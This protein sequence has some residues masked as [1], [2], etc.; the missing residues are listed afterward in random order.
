MSLLIYAEEYNGQNFLS[1]NV[2]DWVDTAFEFLHRVD[3]SAAESSNKCVFNSVGGV[4]WWELTDGSEWNDHGFVGGKTIDL[5]TTIVGVGS[6]IFPATI[7]YIDG[8]KMYFTSD[9][10]AGTVPDQTPSPQFDDATGQLLASVE[11]IQTSAPES[12]EYDFNLANVDNPSLNSLI[13]G[14]INRFKYVDLDL[15][16]ILGTPQIMSPV[17][18]RSGGYFSQPRIQYV[19]NIDGYRKY[20]IVYFFFVWPLIQDGQT[21]PQWF[22]GVD[23][24]GANHRVRVFSQLNN[25]NSILQDKSTNTDGNV[26]GFDENFNTST[27][28]FTITNAI[29]KDTTGNVIEGID[30]CDTT[31][32]EIQIQ[33]SNSRLNTTYSR[34]NIGLLWRPND[35]DEYSNNLNNF[36]K[37]TITN[38]PM[39]DFVHTLTPDP[40]T[41]NGNTKNGAGWA[42]E[43]LQFTITGTL[44]TVKGDIIPDP[45]N[46]AFFD[47]LDEGAKRH[48]LWISPWRIDYANS[49]QFRTSVKVY[50]TDVICAPAVGDPIN[51]QSE[52]FFDHGGNDLSTATTTTEDDVLYNLFF[53]LNIGDV[54]TG[55]KAKIQMYNTA[56]EE[57]FT[58]EEFLIGFN[59]VPFIAGVYEANESINR[60]FN[61][62]PTTDRNEILLNRY[63]ANDVPGEYGLK[64]D[65]GYLNLWRYWE[66]QSNADDEFFDLAQPNNGKNKNWQRF[67]SFA[68]WTPRIAIFM[69]KDNVEDYHY[70][71][72]TI[73]DYDDEDVTTTCTFVDLSDLTTPTSLIANTLIEVTTTMVWNTGTFDP[74]N[75]WFE[76]TIEDY[77]AGNRFVLSSILAQGGVSSNPLKPI[78]GQTMLDVSIAGNIA[79]LKYVIDTNIVDASKVSLTH[80]VWSLEADEGGKIKE[81][82]D[83]KYKEDGDIKIKEE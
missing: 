25:S 75:N 81:D 60:N 71:N 20:R 55:L 9:P 69:V 10:Y 54:Y 74:V 72:Y 12:L 46:V 24:V 2:G 82:G 18:N 29:Y 15:L 36:G 43:N 76:S 28:P 31:N 52:A 83:Q 66:A 26:G 73:R 19:S 67:G 3:Y 58:L 61:L 51:A 44:L 8:E 14:E 45:G 27:N 65:Y 78:T 7:Q 21:E 40:S 5:I 42:F 22:D 68:N 6:T 59:S 4:F 34:F 47:A 53:N 64:L 23:T 13:D 70:A 62:P 1:A 30:Y 77:E 49:E 57:F 38:A 48:T 33:D 79:T 56:T 37:N 50:D 32:F 17:G 39:Q 63:P 41:Y 16:P 11:F 35:S 80:R